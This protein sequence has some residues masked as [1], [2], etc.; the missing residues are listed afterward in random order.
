MY[1]NTLPFHTKIQRGKKLVPWLQQVQA[2][3]VAARQYQHAP[4]QDIQSWSGIQG[5]FVD[6]LLVFLNY[7]LAKVLDSQPWKLQVEKVH[8]HEQNNFPLTVTVTNAETLGVAFTFN[9]DLLDAIYIEGVRDHFKQVLLQIA[10]DETLKVEDL[11]LLT[12]K[13]KETLLDDFNDTAV[14]EPLHLSIPA[15]FEQQVLAT[16]AATALV[17]E[18]RVITYE[19]L[20][21]KSN[22]VAHYLRSCKINKGSFVPLCF[23]RGIEMIIAILGTLKA[24]AAYVP[25]DPALPANR[26]RFML[27]DIASTVLLTNSVNAAVFEDIETINIIEV[28]DE[29][30]LLALQP[31]ANPSIDITDNDLAYVIYTSGSTGTPKGVMVSHGNLKNYLLNQQTA[32]IDT[33][34]KRCR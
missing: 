14:A 34:W 18:D 33:K 27:K 20:N 25:I 10:G 21:A 24:G 30:S 5:D 6:S 23:E 16:P 17:F 12:E 22:Q 13:E 1:I 29:G 11:D 15:L 2:Q 32:Y 9:E 31:T 3:Q 4:L 7:P 8:N 28:D 26:I 19:Q